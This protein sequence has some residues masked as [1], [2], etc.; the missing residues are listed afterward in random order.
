MPA[1]AASDATATAAH[2]VAAG[3]AAVNQLPAEKMWSVM[4]RLN[5]LNACHFFIAT[6]AERPAS[7]YRI[8]FSSPQALDYVPLYRLR[9]GIRGQEVFRPGW[10]VRLDPT[11]L[12]VMQHLD[13]ERSIREIAQRVTQSGVLSR[14]DQAELEYTSRSTPAWNSSRGCG[15]WTSSPW[16][17]AARRADQPRP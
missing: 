5:T 16:T 2:V 13:G 4:E 1:S 17:S 12:A 14:A 7:G 6:N 8:D 9:C 11:H 10:S 15:G 3:A